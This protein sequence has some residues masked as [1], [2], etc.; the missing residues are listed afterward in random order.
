[1]SFPE[2]KSAQNSGVAAIYPQNKEDKANHAKGL[3]EG[4]NG[5]ERAHYWPLAVAIG[6]ILCL[7]GLF[8]TLAAYQVLPHGINAISHLGVWGQV[9]GYGGLG[10]GFTITLIGA[11]KWYLNKQNTQIDNSEHKN[12]SDLVSDS[13]KTE[14][15][16]DGNAVTASV[17][18]IVQGDILKQKV[19][20]IVNAANPSIVGGGGIDG[21]IHDAAGPELADACRQYKIEHKIEKIKVGDAVL[22]SAFNIKNLNTTIQYVIHTVGPDCR[23]SSQEKER[24]HL[25]KSAY[26]NSLEIARKHGIKSVAFPAISTGIYGFPLKEAQH[27]ALQVIKEY[28]VSNPHVF[29]EVLLVYYSEGDFKNALSVWEEIK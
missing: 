24:E 5:K 3:D 12:T 21:M 18:K 2:L 1:M 8:L 27:V 7:A 14:D 15:K 25:L 9:A 10:I 29:S 28:L 13:Q 20:A 16:Q 11:V 19:E 6:A 23:D 17:L 4:V 26:L 22:T